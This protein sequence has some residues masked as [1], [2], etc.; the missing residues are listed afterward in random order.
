MSVDPYMRCRFNEDP[1][2]D[3]VSPFIIGCPI[4]G[5]GVGTVLESNHSDFNV[6][7]IVSCQFGWLW[8]EKCWL[9]PEV[10][11]LQKHDP[12]YDL[13]L[14]S[15]LSVLGIPGTVSSSSF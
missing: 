15:Y 6:G 11:Q 9:K 1:G 14:E 12:L 2:V 8:A 5:G 3:Y 7:D 4:D 13:P 10:V